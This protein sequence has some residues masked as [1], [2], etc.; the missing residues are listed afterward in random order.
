MAN[1]ERLA[2]RNS[3]RMF[4]T[5]TLKEAAIVMGTILSHSENTVKIYDH[6]LNGDISE[7]SYSFYTKLTDF[8]DN[9]KTLQV[10]LRDPQQ[11][12]SKIYHLLTRYAEKFPDQVF[13]QSI[14]S[15]FKNN[16]E[17]ILPR[18]TNFIVNDKNAFRLELDDRNNSTQSKRVEAICSFNNELFSK[19]LNDT[20]EKL[21]TNS[22]PIRKSETLSP[23]L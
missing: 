1:I 11:T 13:L 3:P 7:S 17:T 19:N 12:D 21:Y 16:L 14:K 22:E 8:L 5:H 9:K 15:E 6:C 20:F 18:D 4:H 10:V 2:A 23:N